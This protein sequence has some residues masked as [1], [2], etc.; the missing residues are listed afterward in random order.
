MLTGRQ[1]H[2]IE[3]RTHS[4]PISWAIIFGFRGPINVI[5]VK[6]ISKQFT[7]HIRLERGTSNNDAEATTSDGALLWD[8]SSCGGIH[9]ALLVQ[10]LLMI[11]LGPRV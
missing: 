10:W 5:T 11:G 8:C 4:R 6:K 2:S 9:G 1:S 7:Y 3:V